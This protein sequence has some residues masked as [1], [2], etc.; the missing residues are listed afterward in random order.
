MQRELD[1]AGESF[2]SLL[3]EVRCELAMRYVGNP[4]YSLVEVSELLGY[5]SPSTFTR[6]F[7]AQFGIAPAVWRRARP[8]T[9][10]VGHPERSATGS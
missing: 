4:R 5:S 7:S 1:K 8:A 3:N 9:V 2:T 10:N 6:W